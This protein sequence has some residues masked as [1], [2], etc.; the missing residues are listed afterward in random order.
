MTDGVSKSVLRNRFRRHWRKGRTEAS[1]WKQCNILL[2]YKHFKSKIFTWK[3]LSCSYKT[4]HHSF[5]ILQHGSDTQ[6]KNGCEI[7]ATKKTWRKQIE[8]T[9]R[10]I[11]H[12][13]TCKG[14]AAIPIPRIWKIVWPCRLRFQCIYTLCGTWRVHET[15]TSLSQGLC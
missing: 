8:Q 15:M 1:N 13:P 3:A 11:Q 12:A 6:K 2:T 10:N 9:P 4:P 7:R 14:E 5:L